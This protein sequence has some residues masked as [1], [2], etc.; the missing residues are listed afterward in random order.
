MNCPIHWKKNI[1]NRNDIWYMIIDICICFLD[2]DTCELCS[3]S[4]LFHVHLVSWRRTFE[5]LSL[6][7]CSEPLNSQSNRVG[8]SQ[9]ISSPNFLPKLEPFGLMK[10]CRHST[11]FKTRRSTLTNYCTCSTHWINYII[12]QFRNKEKNIDG[13]MYSM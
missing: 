4:F 8:E 5:R 1:R 7:Q 11:F 3:L 6:P 10:G 9:L 13:N 2:L 12:E